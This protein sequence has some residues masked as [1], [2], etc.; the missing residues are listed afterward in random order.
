MPGLPS[1]CGLEKEEMELFMREY[2]TREEQECLRR[3]R[4]SGGNGWVCI[5]EEIIQRDK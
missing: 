4:L 5:A 3:I 1:V 2:K